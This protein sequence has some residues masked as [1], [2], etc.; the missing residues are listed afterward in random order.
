[1]KQLFAIHIAWNIRS[2]ILKSRKRI[3]NWKN[4]YKS[5]IV[6]IYEINTEII[7]NSFLEWVGN[8]LPITGVTNLKSLQSS[9][10]SAMCAQVCSSGG[11]QCP[12]GILKSPVAESLVR[13]KKVNFYGLNSDSKINLVSIPSSNDRRSPSSGFSNCPLATAVRTLDPQHTR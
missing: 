7:D 2:C 5:K 11:Q 4:K 6:H 9:L 12:R 1:M 10:N 8:V 13:S 3:S